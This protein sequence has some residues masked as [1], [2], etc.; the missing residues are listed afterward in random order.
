MSVS[1]YSLVGL[2]AEVAGEAATLADEGADG[3]LDALGGGNL[4][5]V[6]EHERAAEDEGGGVGGEERQDCR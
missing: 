2:A 5:H 3:T 4:A 6:A 1:T